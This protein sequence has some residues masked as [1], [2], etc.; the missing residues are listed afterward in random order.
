MK[1][2][3]LIIGIILG[4]GTLLDGQTMIGLTKDEVVAKVKQEYR[5]FRKDALVIKQQFNYLKYVNRDRTRTWILYFTNEDLC[6]TSKLICDYI[7]FDEVVADLN[8]KYLST[9]DLLWEYTLEPGSEKN[10]NTRG[11]KRVSKRANKRSRLRPDTIQ[12]ELEKL[13]WYFTIRETKKQGVEE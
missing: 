8:S 12:V 7:D 13:E 4:V 5:E 3:V 6:S 10:S 9:G 1:R 2:I 11:R